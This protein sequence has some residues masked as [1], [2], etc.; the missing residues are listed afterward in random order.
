[1]TDNENVRRD[2]VR[3]RGT[4]ISVER[5]IRDP[6]VD[7]REEQDTVRY[8]R[9]YIRDGPTADER[10]PVYE[11]APFTEWVTS[12]AASVGSGGVDD[13]IDTRADGSAGATAGMTHRDGEQVVIVDRNRRP[14]SQQDTDRPS[15]DELVDITPESA[16]VTVTLEGRTRTETFGVWVEES[17]EV[18]V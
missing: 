8:V 12:K 1:M 10:E 7:Y 2:P 15:F 16:T 5:T 4:P 11:T 17:N 14:D 13:A 18:P 9:A 3:G 6:Q